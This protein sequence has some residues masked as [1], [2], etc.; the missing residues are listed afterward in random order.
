VVGGFF[1][2]E[3]G[4]AGAEL[5]Q[6]TGVIDSRHDFETSLQQKTTG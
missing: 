4:E 1:L 2:A 5:R 3:G 6:V